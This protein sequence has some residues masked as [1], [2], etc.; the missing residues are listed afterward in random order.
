MGSFQITRETTGAHAEQLLVFCRFENSFG[1][2][3]GPDV[4]SLI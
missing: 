4:P 2:H 3:H 1:G